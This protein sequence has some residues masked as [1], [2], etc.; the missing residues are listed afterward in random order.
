MMGLPL[1][2]TIPA[3]LAA[4][5]VLPALYFLLRLT[6]P[7]PQAVAFPPLRL[8]LDLRPKD[9]TPARTPLW[10]LL[11]RLLVAALLILAMAGPVWNPAPSLGGGKGPL[12]VVLDDSFAAAPDW[13][14]RVT[15]ARQRLLSAQSAGRV[16]AILATSDGPRAVEAEDATRAI[17]RL[18]A[19][20]PV[21]IAPDRAPVLAALTSFATANPALDIVWMTDGLERGGARSF[22][23]GLTKLPGVNSVTSVAADTIPLALA[24][25]DNKADRLDV[26]VIRANTGG[27]QRGTVQALDAKGL[28]IGE[29]TFAFT[30]GQ[31]AHAGFDLP[32][33]LRND[34]VRVVIANEAS[35]AATTLLDGRST[36]RRVGV[37]TGATIDVEQPLLSPAYYIVKALGPFADVREP[38][39]GMLDP[40]ASMLDDNPSVMVLADVGALSGPAHDRLAKFIDDGG[41]LIRFAGSRLAGSSDDL[42]PVAL[43]RGGR[44]F[45]GALSWDKP[46]ALA[47][48]ERGSPF[49]GLTVPQEVSVTRQVLAE[50]SAGLPG[51]T[52]AQLVDGT[53]LVTA[54]KRGKG[55]I[56]L[57]HVTADTTWSNLPLSVLFV[58]ML[59][60]VVDLSGMP[61]AAQRSASATGA[62][63]PAGVQQ[64]MVIAP[65]RSLDGFG[66]L[67]VP[68]AT[69]RPIPDTYDGV[70]TADHPPGFY[71]PSDA[72]IAV[73]TLGPKDMLTPADLSGLPIDRQPL[74]ADP[75]IDLRPAV[76][77]LALIGFLLDALASV[78]LGGGLVR[79][80]AGPA[81]AALLAVAL[82]VPGLPNLPGGAA[83]AA[84]Q[85][86]VSKRD[87]ASALTT[88]IAY[89]IT[90]DTAVDQASS[91]GLTT[92]STALADRTSLTPG[93]PVGVDPAKD[94]LAFYPMI[95]WPVVASMPQP[96]ATTV[97]RIAA[98]MK[99]GG[100]IVFDTRDALTHRTDGP[101]TPE[102]DWLQ[103]L[104]A[105]VDVPE[106]EPVPS[107]HV[108]TKTFY[109][110]PGFVGRY[111]TGQTW[112]EALPPAAKETANRPV[113]AGDSVSPIIITGNDLASGWAADGQG[114]PVYPLVPGGSR[115]REM[116]LRGGINLVIYTLTGNYKADQVH[117]RD[118]LE[119][120]AH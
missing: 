115:Q 77:T 36:R 116:A 85:P 7:R 76:I 70:A 8:I 59:R 94:E 42:V 87:M 28:P 47:P 95:Y 48:F 44:T 30:S 31:E 114:E 45:G 97:D 43:R 56:V 49:Y 11:L 53:P 66:V 98:Y 111:T 3:V 15:L 100:T 4:L 92:L 41:T 38:R 54:E 22:G 73:N 21:P 57:F 89:V 32:V 90:G 23:E 106:L 61:G 46:K 18:Q 96:D 14:A 9:E 1:A 103:H 86:P 55:R 83:H 78:W 120:L 5:A 37:V 102:A 52:W 84:G 93:E 105:G 68:P 6:P 110:L 60:R 91:L 69:A 64:P 51:K 108:V 63:S 16:T 10:L 33:E 50:P 2:F 17:E 75:A 24:G 40:V 67:G 109:L 112:I 27:P 118:L 29:S 20:K 72:S 117:V 113:R 39:P 74:R 71:G 79:R 25:A 58:D 12:V 35:A 81:A 65:T 119:R 104:L 13:D 82:M 80:G 88:R 62:A 101:P 34:I 19:L 107:D 26:R 99:Q